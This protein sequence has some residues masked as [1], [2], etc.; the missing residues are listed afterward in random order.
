MAKSIDLDPQTLLGAYAQG[1]FPMGG[2]D[3]AI[4][5]YTADP[6]GILPLEQFHLPR[7]E[8]T[9]VTD[10][11]AGT[12]DLVFARVGDEGDRDALRDAGATLVCTTLAETRDY[13]GGL[14]EIPRIPVPG[15][16]DPPVVAT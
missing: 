10:P 16:D 5:W 11:T 13:L 1:A 14:V 3:G 12:A 15:A 9:V 7:T 2:R 4:R 6:R 8:F